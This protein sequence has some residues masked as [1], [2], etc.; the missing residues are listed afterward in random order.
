MSD[1]TW[2]T[3]IKESVSYALSIPLLFKQFDKFK[4]ED[5]ESSICARDL[6]PHILDCLRVCSDIDPEIRHSENNFTIHDIRHSFNVITL[7][8][9]LVDDINELSIL[10]I[11]FLIYSALL[12]DIGMIRLGDEEISDEEIREYHGERTKKFLE[13]NIIRLN[14][15]T[16]LNFGIY[17]TVFM[18]YLP[19]LCASHMRDFQSI[20]AFPNNMLVNSIRINLRLCA[21]LLRLADAMDISSNRA[22]FAVYNLLKLKGLSNEHWKKHMSITDCSIIDGKYRIEGSCNDERVIRVL[23][24]NLDMIQSELRKAITY[25]LKS[26]DLTHLVVDSEIIDVNIRTD[27][28]EIRNNTLTLDYN[29]I[30]N[31]F[32]GEHL[33]GTKRAG[34]REII[35]NSIDACLVRKS[36]NEK[37][38]LKDA[39]TPQISVAIDNEHIYVRDNGIGMT[40]EVIEKY[41]LNVGLSYYHSNEFRQKELDYSPIGFFGIGFLACFM[42]SDDIIVKTAS[43]KDNIEYT[44]HLVKDDRFVTIFEYPRTDFTGTEIVFEKKVFF[45][46]FSE[47]N[48]KELSEYEQIND[49]KNYIEDTFWRMKKSGK[50]YDML[51]NL[52]S[53]SFYS[54]ASRQV[55]EKKYVIN[56]SDYLI[57][58]EGVMS[59]NDDQGLLEMWQDSGTKISDFVTSLQSNTIEIEGCGSK[60]MPFYSK[61][62][63]Y[64]NDEF[65]E[66]GDRDDLLYRTD[67]ILIFIS[68]RD[69]YFDMASSV[70]VY[71]PRHFQERIFLKNT[72]IQYERTYIPFNPTYFGTTF[73]KQLLNLMNKEVHSSYIL[74]PQDKSIY[75]SMMQNTGGKPEQ[76]NENTTCYL[77]S[78]KIGIPPM[79]DNWL[80]FK[81]FSLMINIQNEEIEPQ[82][83]RSKLIELSEHY[84]MNAIEI[85]KYLWL[86]KNI[87]YENDNA[88]SRFLKREILS[89]WENKNP[90][91]KKEM[92]PN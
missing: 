42:L 87:G 39:Y 37:K 24:K 84:V 52:R 9:Q 80:L 41:F 8:S 36:E 61:S 6:Q 50:Q 12:H 91:L 47:I 32:M 33:Y 28:Y 77:K 44:L 29:S 14:S 59:F 34:L 56:I 13:N 16:E 55:K 70:P 23:Y 5:D 30:S 25:S 18:E 22:P 11:G 43:Y 45:R 51:Y 20:L 76:E 19:D 53:T 71:L 57:N 63:V 3:Q 79:E 35:Q 60:S 86:L 48:N 15:G 17:H 66:I 4:K 82:A 10:E 89:L 1:K 62:F 92:K 49:I 21:V 54:Y 7:M 83:S 81:D 72:I 26:N 2:I 78:A 38:I 58:I 64:E 75:W 85:T 69:R 73:S 67:Y 68:R 40:R 46:N 65:I 27:G 90:L 74:D 88:T 31:L